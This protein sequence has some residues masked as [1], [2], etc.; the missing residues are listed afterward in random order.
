MITTLPRALIWLTLFGVLLT[1][2]VSGGVSNETDPVQ[3][4][5]TRLPSRVRAVDIP[6]VRG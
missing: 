5:P 3:D 2:A 1:E 6:V 4:T